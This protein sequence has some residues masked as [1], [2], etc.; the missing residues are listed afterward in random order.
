[1]GDTQVSGKIESGRTGAEGTEFGKTEI[2]VFSEEERNE[3]NARI[4]AASARE[5]VD[6][7][8]PPARGEA[9]KRSMFPLLVNV[10]GVLLLGAALFFLTALQKSG[11][12]EIRKSASVLDITAQALIQ[13][14]RREVDLQLTEKD[15]AIDEMNSRITEVDAELERLDSLEELTGEQRTLMEELHRQQEEYRGSLSR[16]QIERARILANAWQRETEARQREAG[17][18]ARLAEQQ[19]ALENLSAQSR[20]EIQAARDELAKLAD[21]EEKSLL[22][23]KQLSAYYA[24]LSRQIQAGQY[25]EAAG[26]I[27]ALREYLSTPAFQNLR[28]FQA[29]RESDAAAL[30]ALESL[31]AEALTA[32]TPAQAAAPAEIPVV[33]PGAGAEAELRRQLADRNAALTAREG[34]LAE[35]EKSYSALQEQNTA[36]QQTVAERERQIESLQAQNAANL[37][38][39]ETLQKTISNVN[40]ALGE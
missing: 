37:Q 36:M 3:I 16:L 5:A 6:P 20:A 1:M 7:P 9:A 39:I 30:N 15:Q 35:L 17:L 40:A 34:S 18:H 10:L 8:R 25:R 24:V 2:E 23:E 26:T 12:V 21:V 14:I 32:G 22:A 33:P 28:S 38:K 11:T 19:G 27:A 29:R 31:A 13:E 4:E